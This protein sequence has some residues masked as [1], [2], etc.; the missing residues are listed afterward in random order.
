MTDQ[1][2]LM[3]TFKVPTN[4][5]RAEQ[6]LAHADEVE[7]ETRNF[8]LADSLRAEAAELMGDNND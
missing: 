2:T 4:H 5:Q 6:M 8:Q 7:W 1:D 3:A